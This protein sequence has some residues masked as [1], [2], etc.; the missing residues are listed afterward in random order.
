MNFTFLTTQTTPWCGSEN[1]WTSAAFHLAERHQVNALLPTS[2]KHPSSLEAFSRNRVAV[3]LFSSTS[4]PRR[5]ARRAM[6][7]VGT[8]SRGFDHSISRVSSSPDAVIINH[9]GI[10]DPLFQDGLLDWAQRTNIPYFIML[11]SGRLSGQ[12]TNEQ[13]KL[14]RDYYT[15]ARQ[16]F[17]A[18][19]TNQDDLQFSLLGDFPK[20][21]WIHSPVKNWQSKPLPWP[22]GEKLRFGCVGRLDVAEKGL[23]LLIRAFSSDRWRT[24]DITVDLYGKGNDEDYVKGLIHFLGQQER[25]KVCGEYQSIEQAW[26]PLHCHILLSRSE[27]TPQSLMESL[28]AARPAVVTPVGG[29]PNLVRNGKDGFIADSTRLSHVEAALESI[30]ESRNCLRHLGQNATQHVRGL[31]RESPEEFLVET[32]RKDMP[33]WA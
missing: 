9:G 28:I 21:T 7:L 32:I 10:S 25:I 17:P 2:W 15:G 26:Q 27:G 30:W 33:N 1:L 3:H 16:I 5:I 14:L 18:A 8:R 11:R 20:C 12:M 23:D 6:K 19:P 24:R 22:Q 4:L 29:M 13:R 31:L